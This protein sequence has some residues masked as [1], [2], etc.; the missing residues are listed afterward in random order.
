MDTGEWSGFPERG[1]PRTRFGALKPQPGWSHVTC[2]ASMCSARRSAVLHSFS[3]TSGGDPLRRLQ[4]TLTTHSQNTTNT[5]PN[6]QN[7]T[8]LRNPEGQT[9]ASEEPLL[10][11]LWEIEFPKHG[12]L[13]RRLQ[14]HLDLTSAISPT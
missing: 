5:P 8:K 13:R 7:T 12:A 3:H 4:A 9:L 10:Q 11:T 2:I 1:P 6:T 14:G